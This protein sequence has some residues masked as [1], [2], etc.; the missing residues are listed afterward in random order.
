MDTHQL[1]VTSALRGAVVRA[2]LASALAAGVAAVAPTA[3]ARADG[4]TDLYVARVDAGGNDV[5]PCTQGEPCATLAAALRAAGPSGTTIHVGP[6]TFDGRVVP[7]DGQSVTIEGVSAGATFLTVPD[8]EQDVDV[9]EVM[10]GTLTLSDLTVDANAASDLTPFGVDIGGNGA[11]RADHVVLTDAACDVASAGSLRIADST[12]G[13]SGEGCPVLDGRD[14][15][16][17]AVVVQGGTA[18]LE[19]TQVLDP[20]NGA[21]GVV[22][23]GG[24]VDI[25]Q[26]Y[27]DRAVP[28][29]GGDSIGVEVKSGT[30]TVSRS[31]LHGFGAGAET[32]DGTALLADD[33][34]EGNQVGVNT[35]GGS[36]TVVRG[37]F[38]HELG[39]LQNTTADPS[40]LSTA[41]SVL[42]PGDIAN[43][44]GL[45]TDLGYNLSSDD[46]CS[47]TRGT[48]RSQVGDLHLDSGLA[49][50]GGPVPTVATLWPS[51][52]IDA[53][54]VGATY[55]PSG[56]SL[57]PARGTTDL[58]GLPRPQG[59]ACDAGSMELASTRTGLVAPRA[60]RPA[61][62][63]A[64]TATVSVPSG[65]PDDPQSAVGTVTF[66][67]GG[68]DLCADVPVV[69]TTARCVT[70]A[71]AP[72][73][74]AV[75]ATFTPAEGRTID[76]SHGSST[77]VVGTRPG[78]KP[79]RTVTVRVGKSLRLR[80]HAWGLPVPAV[81]LVRGHLPQGLSFHRRG[82]GTAVIH[83]RVR[84]SAK[85]RYHLVVE[86]TNLL[87]HD[88]AR[89]RIVVRHRR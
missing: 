88:R 65:L 28:D 26:S 11:V 51:V 57:C 59:G 6:G 89:V 1:K 19:R 72:G 42:G 17:A 74:R 8:D 22:V 29:T 73:R 61:H 62:E 3:S 41:G 32:R 25:D 10:S 18:S 83:G 64:L 23:L 85:G 82:H 60:A 81:R 36:T 70:S 79:R 39:E 66:R 4:Q 38:A 80:L 50:H 43:C 31:T 37:T 87:G 63:I 35:D 53:I 68:R 16:N 69:T 14:S 52:A 67:S 13:D 5:N 40:R 44:I 54:P 78:I 47:W 84:A 71:L 21:D 45:V 27:V 12:I 48:S 49:D 7:S 33:T 2:L 15:G 20:G 34:F 77:T 58:R 24:D 55:G 56:S 75:V 30:V 76:S 9:V 46:T 86:A